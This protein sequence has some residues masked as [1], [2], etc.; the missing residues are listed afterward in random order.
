MPVPQA[1]GAAPQGP[2]TDH[3]MGQALQAQALWDA[4]MGHAVAEALDAHRGALVVHY[5]GSFHVESGTGIPERIRDYRPRTRTVVV[6]LQPAA[7]INAWEDEE[8]R[9]LGDF[10]IL[11][12]KPPDSAGGG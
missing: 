9:D 2:P 1:P 10:V 7:D 6:F 11:T 5:V 12:R 8:H 3:G 4:A